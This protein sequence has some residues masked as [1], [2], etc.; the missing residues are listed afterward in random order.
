[1]APPVLTLRDVRLRYGANPLFSRVELAIAATDRLCLVGRNGA[2]KSTLLKVMAGLVEPDTGERFL[3]PGLKVEYVAQEPDFGRH[4]TLGGYVSAAPHVAARLLAEVGLD[5]AR[6]TTGLSGGERRRAALARAFAAEPDLLLLDEPTNH[7]DIAAIEWLE[8]RLAVHRGAAVVISHDRMFLRRVTAGILWLDRGITRQKNIGFDRFEAWMEEVYAAEDA[9]RAR[10]EKK[11]AEETHWLHRGVTARRRRNQGRLQRLLDM[12]QEKAGQIARLGNV[13][14][15]ADAGAMSGKI[16]IE[17]RN[18][19][20]ALGGKTLF[21]NFTTR[22]GRGDRIGIIGP[23]GA[24]KTTLLQVLLGKLPPDAGAVKHGAGLTVAYLDQARAG[25]KDSDTVVDVLS[26]GNDFVDVR[27]NRQHVASY[28]RDF[29]FTTDQLRAPVSALSGGECNRL[30]L[31]RALAKP[32]N[33]LVLDEPT[34]NLDMD[35]LDLLQETLAD[36]DGTL[37]LVS[38]DRDF[39]D[40]VVTSTIVLPGDGTAQEFAGG[41]S[42]YMKQRPREADPAQ[43]AKTTVK[44]T[45]DTTSTNKSSRLSYKHKRRLDMLPDEIAAAQKKIETLREKLADPEFYRRDAAAFARV[46]AELQD[47]ENRL[48]RLED[49]WLELEVLREEADGNL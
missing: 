22:I 6:A 8:G 18:I 39:L 3:Q 41:Y 14:L 27:G 24:G 31:A 33:L 5:P 45:S 9:E 40:R 48:Q 30:M 26:G 23:N 49:E 42:D 38:H 25:L 15:A 32:S 47:L 20:K 12:R 43:T 34:N 37:L 21:E 19:S 13:A 35:T 28:A 4:A 7:L 17:A 46:S 16:V 11:I 36:Y 2:G 44:P 29:L 10:L 1:M